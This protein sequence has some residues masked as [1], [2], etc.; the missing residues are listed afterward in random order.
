MSQIDWNKKTVKELK[1]ICRDLE[2]PLQSRVRK[3]EIIDQICDRL[4]D[5]AFYDPRDTNKTWSEVRES[6]NKGNREAADLC[7][8]K[9]RIRLSRA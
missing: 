2:I 9:T 6:C 8:D 5:L 7:S 1:N 3:D 4:K